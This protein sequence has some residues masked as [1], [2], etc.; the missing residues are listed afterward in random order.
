MIACDGHLAPLVI[1]LSQQPAM[2]A[3]YVNDINVLS[4]TRR[5]C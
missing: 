2:A 4:L 1:D 3:I 5:G